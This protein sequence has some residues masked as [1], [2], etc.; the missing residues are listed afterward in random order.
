MMD[1][2]EYLIYKGLQRP[3]AFMGLQGRYIGW[4]AIGAGC[5]FITFAAL[6]AINKQTY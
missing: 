3:L 5:S 4:A 6:L 1:N 2:Q